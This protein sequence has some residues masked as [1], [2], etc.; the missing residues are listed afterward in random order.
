MS[1]LD[2]LVGTWDLTMHH[3]AMTEPVRGRET[4]RPILD[5]AFLE[6]QRTY[7]HPDFPDAIAIMS[8]TRTHYFD[9]R[10]ISRVFTHELSDRGWS[11]ARSSDGEAFAQRQSITFTTPDTM[12]GIG[13][14]SP[15][16]G[17][18][19]QHDYTIHLERV[20]ADEE[21]TDR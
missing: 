8:E 12:N 9:V 14:L 16:D 18:T 6:M 15:D 3:T 20:T 2:R 1:A 13:E 19:W 11:S 7:D 17:A 10:G 5:G 4:Y 21:A